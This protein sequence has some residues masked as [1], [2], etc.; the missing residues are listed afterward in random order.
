V[1]IAV[2]GVA[3]AWGPGGTTIAFVDLDDGT[4]WGAGPTGADRRRLLPESVRGVTAVAWSPDARTLAFSTA[5]G[6]YVAAPDGLSAPREVIAA[7]LP[8]RPSFSPDGRRIAYAA[9][10]HSGAHV[11]RAVFAVGVDGKGGRQLTT[12]PYDSSDPAWRP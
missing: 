1:S 12:G 4:V 11:Y 9:D 2:D 7:T 8:G 5:S 3:P 6:L 10:A